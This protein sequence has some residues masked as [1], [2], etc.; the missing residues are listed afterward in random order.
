M[1]IKR[2]CSGLWDESPRTLVG[3][4]SSNREI[5]LCASQS[6]R[7][8]SDYV[9]GNTIRNVSA[10]KAKVT[11]RLMAIERLAGLDAR[12]MAEWPTIQ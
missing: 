1:E 4:L 7:A 12:R 3:D 8:S 5:R 2:G 6:I 9:K 11:G 10:A